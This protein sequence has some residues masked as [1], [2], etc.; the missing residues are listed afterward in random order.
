MIQAG[1]V[2]VSGRAR[3][4]NVFEHAFI[5]WSLCA[6]GEHRMQG[7]RRQSAIVKTLIERQGERDTSGQSERETA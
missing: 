5:E 1:R 3:V 6:L 4:G 2:G 7:E